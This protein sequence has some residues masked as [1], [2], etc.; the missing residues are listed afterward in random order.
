MRPTLGILIIMATVFG[1]FMVAGGSL[2][3]FWQPAEYIIILGAA[4]GS[5]I[6]ANS[7]VV[8][9]EMI[10]GLKGVFQSKK[11]SA[12]EVRE[13]LMVMHELLM[14]IR[15]KGMVGL[16]DHVE[17]PWGSSIFLP[18]EKVLEK[19]LLVNFIADNL[20]MLAM[21]GK[22]AA[23]EVDALLD[24]EIMAIEEDL[25]KPAEAL[26]STGEAMPGFG[27]LAA[28]GG[29]VIT[30][31]YIDA[32]LAMIGMKVAAAL[33]GTFLG[34]FFCYCL[35]EPLASS[36]KE[37]VHRQVTELECI[38]AIIISNL[39][40]KT[41]LLSVDAGR[42]VIE[43]DIKPSFASMEKWIKEESDNRRNM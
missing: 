23:H 2:M 35:L 28:V 38:K 3:A 29:I 5:M 40:G 27:I 9:K 17:N 15:E 19:T 4:M 41:P 26:H 42:R 13:I 14:V 32:G 37:D 21:A 24:K 16:D 36:M 11:E 20:R 39:E 10:H 7:T 31:G 30:M 33:I 1:G 6:V 22:P 25:L 8:L 34:I 18:F 43:L 12:N